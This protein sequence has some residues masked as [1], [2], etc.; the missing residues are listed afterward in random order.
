MST[1][2]RILPVFLLASALAPTGASAIQAHPFNPAW[3]C[4]WLLN[5]VAP[6]D[7]KVLDS[8]RLEPTAS[9]SQISKNWVKLRA[10]LWKDFAYVD[11][12]IDAK[13]LINAEDWEDALRDMPDSPWFKY[14]KEPIANF[15]AVTFLVR[16]D[17]GGMDVDGTL[18]Q[19]FHRW[20][21]RG[22]P[23][24]GFEGRRLIRRFRNGEITQAEL[25]AY[26]KRAYDGNEEIAGVR[27]YKL[28]G[29][30][31]HEAI[32]EIEHRGSSFDA[33]KNRYFTAEE[34]DAHRKNPYLR[35]DETSIKPRPEGG[36]TGVVRYFPAKDVEN[37][38]EK[39]IA[40]RMTKITQ[41]YNRGRPLEELVGEISGLEKDL[42]SIHPFLDGNGRS[43]RAL[44]DLLYYRFN[45]PTPLHPNE[46][47]LLF[48]T[49][50]AIEYVRKEMIKST[51]AWID[52]AKEGVK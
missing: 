32:D 40:E 6:L 10:E 18:L 46:N 15:Y 51:N 1:A 27:H 2:W 30:Y 21:M 9:F 35:V 24:H 39:V 23:F 14:G 49:V 26:L 22:L 37:V 29:T 12:A 47:D 13:R 43:I 11:A 52:S 3:D 42:V 28:I 31:R 36:F 41:L 16:R 50:E 38:V 17:A 34:L 8:S 4:A 48:S 33:N 25:K 7:P 20:A 5:H 19:F 44:T 45:L